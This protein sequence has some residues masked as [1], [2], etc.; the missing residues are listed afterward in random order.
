[1]WGIL[2]VVILSKVQDFGTLVLC[3]LIIV[4]I[5]IHESICV[6]DVVLSIYLTKFYGFV[7]NYEQ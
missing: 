7:Y 3:L 2:N 4:P 1:M 5:C 6:F